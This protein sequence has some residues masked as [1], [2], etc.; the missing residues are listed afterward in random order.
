MPSLKREP[1]RYVV[2]V[3]TREPPDVKLAIQVNL[4]DEIE[5]VALPE[6]DFALPDQDSCL[7]GVERKRV[8]DFLG[9]L[10]DGRLAKQL[11]RM[12]VTYK[13]QGL[14]VE[15]DYVVT[16]EG[17]LSC[18]GFSTRWSHA[19]FQMTLYSLQRQFPALF[20]LWSNNLGTTA[21]IIRALAQRGR[22][23]CFDDTSLLVDAQAIQHARQGSTRGP[24][25]FVAPC[26]PAPRRSRGK[27]PAVG[28]NPS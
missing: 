18:D 27:S 5:L 7:M 28:R 15:G 23:G 22:K 6:G 14:I 17:Y 19:S 26:E 11:T 20:V 24:V 12:G 2:L 4:P 1:R 16:G 21:D 10:K 9:S 13:I 8:S 3:D 25:P